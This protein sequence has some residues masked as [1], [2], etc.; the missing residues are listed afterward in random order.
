MIEYYSDTV[1]VL[2]TLAPNPELYNILP[3]L[4]PPLKT[5][6]LTIYFGLPV[7]RGRWI[8]DIGCLRV[9]PRACVVKTFAVSL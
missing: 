8:I 2:T 6:Y 7:F 9:G 4:N 1:K 5:A 3:V